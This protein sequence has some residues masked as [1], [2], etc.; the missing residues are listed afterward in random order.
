MIPNLDSGLAHFHKELRL[1]LKF[2][3]CFHLRLGVSKYLECA[4]S[5]CCY[6]F[7]LIKNDKCPIE[8]LTLF[9]STKYEPVILYWGAQ[10]M[11]I[12]TLIRTCCFRCQLSTSRLQEG[13]KLVCFLYHTIPKVQNRAWNAVKVVISTKQLKNHLVSIIGKHIQI[14]PKILYIDSNC[15]VYLNFIPVNFS[16]FFF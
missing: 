7:I 13:R 15:C 6:R 9:A 10:E 8:Q 2:S 12:N 1:C 5:K 11:L 3:S 14:F 4:K 16:H